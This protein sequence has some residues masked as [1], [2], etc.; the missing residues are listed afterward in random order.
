MKINNSSLSF[1]QK[2]NKFSGYPKVQLALKI[3]EKAQ[4]ESFRLQS[5]LKVQVISIKFYLKLLNFI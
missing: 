5:E 4:K 3:I 2:A 1:G